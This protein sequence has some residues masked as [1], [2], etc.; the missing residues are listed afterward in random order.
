VQ[1]VGQKRWYV[2]TDP[3]GLQNNWGD[4]AEP[5]PHLE[6]H[7]VI[8]VGP[9]DLHYVP[10]GTPHS[11]DSTTDSIHVSILFT[12]LTMRAAIVA[13]L[14]HASDMARP[15]RVTAASRITGVPGLG[16]ALGPGIVAGLTHLIE[17]C[18]QPG[19]VEAALAKRA[20]REIGDLARLTPA[21]APGVALSPKDRIRHA[22]LS[23]LHLRDAG[24]VVDLALP[25]GHMA[26]HPGA[27]PALAFIAATSSF[28]IAE[29]PG[30]APEVS[31]ALVERLIAAGIL[32][33]EM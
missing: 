26:I 5:L 13:A 15:Y 23:I 33:P 30:L 32:E 2:S 7:R 17:Q 12:P 31:V 29:L 20:G 14:D 18:R 22:P 21:I 6:R 11:V 9:G 16:S 8:D 10:R 1:L 27:A 28:A 3:A 24:S 25:G 19:F 4:V